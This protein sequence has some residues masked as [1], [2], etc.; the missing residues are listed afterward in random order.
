MHTRSSFSFGGRLSYVVS[1]IVTNALA[2]LCAWSWTQRLD[3]LFEVF[4]ASV[5]FMLLPP[6]LLARAGAFIQPLSAGLGESG[7]RKYASR[8]V[9]GIARAFDEVSAVARR[10]TEFV[11][12]NDIASVFDRAADAACLRCKRR[13][14]CWV[15]GYMDV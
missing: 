3:A 11:N 9:E 7:L 5:I 12:D 14:E 6:G 8:R 10:N 4:A 2:V 13:D 1:F 15:K